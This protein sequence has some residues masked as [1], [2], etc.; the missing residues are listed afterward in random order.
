MPANGDE[1]QH[2][3]SVSRAHPARA[4]FAPRVVSRCSEAVGVEISFLGLD[5]LDTVFADMV[6]IPIVTVPIEQEAP[7]FM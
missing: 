5:G 1:K 6:G 7:P 2:A 3:S 4:S